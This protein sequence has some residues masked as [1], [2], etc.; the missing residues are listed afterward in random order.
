MKKFL[1]IVFSVFLLST[2]VSLSANAKSVDFFES[3]DNIY[4]LDSYKINQSVH[5]SFNV[6]SYEGDILGKYRVN[7]VSSINNEDNLNNQ[8][9]KVRLQLELNT[10]DFDKE[11]MPFSRLNINMNGEVKVILSDGIYFKLNNIGINVKDISDNDKEDM[12]EMLKIAEEYSGQWYRVGTDNASEMTGHD[13]ESE[14]SDQSEQLQLLGYKGFMEEM[15]SEVI[16]SE[17]I[18]AEYE[19]DILNA[20]NDFFST[21]FLKFQS[22]NRGHNKG[23]TKFILDKTSVFNLVMKYANDF[24]GETSSREKNMFRRMLNKIRISGMYRLNNIYDVYDNFS[25]KAQLHD[26]EELKDLK[27]NYRFRISKINKIPVIT[28]PSEYVDIME[29]GL[30]PSYY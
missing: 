24:G 6:D 14:Y 4:K 28:P 1:S 21:K 23:F 30:I 22:I 25:I 13:L 26:I 5:G 17:G 29:S 10:K 15:I 3:I 16:Q 19:D 20:L 9:S 8:D 18:P 7:I 11:D 12:N 27:M 2:F